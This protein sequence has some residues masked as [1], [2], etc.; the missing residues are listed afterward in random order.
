MLFLADV[1]N[2][3]HAMSSINRAVYFKIKNI[4]PAV[5][6]MNYVENT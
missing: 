6:R 4:V 5:L 3:I 2:P 1:P